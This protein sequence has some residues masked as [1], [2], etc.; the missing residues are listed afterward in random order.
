[1]HIRDYYDVPGLGDYALAGGK[2]LIF[3]AF[4][5]LTWTIVNRITSFDD[6][7]AIFGEHNVAYA[8]QRGGLVLGQAIGLTALISSKSDDAWEDLA[9]LVGGGVWVTGL[10][11]GIRLLLH[12]MIPFNGD[13]RHRTVS[14][15]LVR[16]AFYVASGLVIGAGLSGTAPTLAKALVSTLVF[17]LLGLAVLVGTYLL[18]GR[19]PPFDLNTRVRNGNTAAALI[20]GGFLV[21]LGF[22]LRNAIAGDFTG[23]AS[24]L[25]GFAITGI[26]AL[27]AFYVLCFA[28]DRWIITNTTL[29]KAIEGD[30]ALAAGILSIALIALAL[31]VSLIAI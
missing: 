31:G 11:L 15:G 28:V 20:A 8:L 2:L 30:H 13:A 18:N 29:A 26:V 19:I 17:T 4:I 5:V 16:G 7:H 10:L 1:M 23:W 22:V 9:W 24:G 14:V 6:H 3:A 21:A 27:F 12:T 25:I